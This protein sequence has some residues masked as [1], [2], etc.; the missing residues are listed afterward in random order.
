[1]ARVKVVTDNY[2]SIKG[3]CSLFILIDTPNI[4]LLDMLSD[5]GYEIAGVYTDPQE[6]DNRL[7]LHTGKFRILI[8]ETGRGVFTTAEL[9]QSISDLL[10]HSTGG[11]CISLL[12]TNE[13]LYLRLKQVSEANNYSLNT[14]E[15]N[16][17]LSVHKFLLRFKEIYVGDSYREHRADL[18][19]SLLSTTIDVIPQDEITTQ[20]K[21]TSLE[22]FNHF[23]WDDNG[24]S[25]PSFDSIKY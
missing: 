15:Y 12:Y 19:N 20:T 5:F 11:S 23:E 3:E 24:N 1:M 16:G 25:L 6:L 17:S 13:A 21:L 14:Q 10:G 18:V 22:N 9:K 4:D 7:A 8:V 2:F